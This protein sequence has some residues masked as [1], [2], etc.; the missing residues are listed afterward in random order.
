MSSVRCQIAALIVSF[1]SLCICVENSRAQTVQAKGFDGCAEMPTS[2]EGAK[3]VAD[4]IVEDVR[5]MDFLKVYGAFEREFREA[6]GESQFSD[7]FAGLL[8]RFGKPLDAKFMNAECGTK[9][10]LAGT[11]KPLWKFR[12]DVQT[13]KYAWGE[14]YLSI[15]VVFDKGQKVLTAVTFGQFL[16]KQKYRDNREQ[17]QPL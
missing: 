16:G 15:E 9:F 17:A 8:D 14:Y 11:K 2:F 7:A 13:T 3:K 5:K 4:E 1:L 10:Y 12:Y 6:V